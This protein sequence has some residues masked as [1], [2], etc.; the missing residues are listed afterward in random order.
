[1]GVILIVILVL[2]ILGTLPAWPYIRRLGY[3]PSVCL[4]LVLMGVLVLVITGR[5]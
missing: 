5:L 4:G 3:F 2:L 1:M